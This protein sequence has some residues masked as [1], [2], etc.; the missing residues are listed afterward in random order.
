VPRLTSLLRLIGGV[1]VVAGALS[2]DVMSVTSNSMSETLRPGDLILV[3]RSHRLLRALGSRGIRPARGQLV[4]FHPAGEDAQVKR[5]I[6]IAGDRVHIESDTVV[7][8]GTPVDEPYLAPLA[9]R[10]NWPLTRGG[11]APRD[12]VIPPGHGFYLGDNRSASYDSRHRG[13]VPDTAIVGVV[14]FVWRRGQ[15][16]NDRADSPAPARPPARAHQ[17]F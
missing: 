8:D 2:C 7:R 17:T 16:S 1:L 11:G 6:G 14:R 10:E 13:S 4:V 9:A 12:I 3:D 15:S 5:L